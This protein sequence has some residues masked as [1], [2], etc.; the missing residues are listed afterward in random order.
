MTTAAT[1]QDTRRFTT[2]ALPGEFIIIEVTP[3]LRA[4]MTANGDAGEHEFYNHYTAWGMARAQVQPVTFIG[5][6]GESHDLG[7]VAGS[8]TVPSVR[9]VEKLDEGY[10]T[11]KGEYLKVMWNRAR[12]RLYARVLNT[13]TKHWEYAKGAV[14][15]LGPEHRLTPADAKKFGDVYH[16]CFKCGTELTKPESIERGV[17]PVCAGKLGW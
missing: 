13:A 14:Y 9:P 8:T 1:A 17:G 12:T 2:T 5:L 4:S 16:W 11:L 10:Y 7:V 3:A 6:D 15:E